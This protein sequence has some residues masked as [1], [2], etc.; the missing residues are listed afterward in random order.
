MPSHG[1]N[2]LNIAHSTRTLVAKVDRYVR[3]RERCSQLVLHKLVD[4]VEF[5]LAE[6]CK[7]MKPDAVDESSVTNCLLTLISRSPVIDLCH[8]HHVDVDAKSK[9]FE[10]ARRIYTLLM[11]LNKDI[12]KLHATQLS[13][14]ISDLPPKRPR[15]STMTTTTAKKA[16]TRKLMTTM[17]KLSK[18]WFFGLRLH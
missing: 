5:F 17:F 4:F 10:L 1:D 8:K 3:A 16:K 14:T 12:V 15:V 6:K 2:D 9:H 13:A 11:R 18:R 7:L